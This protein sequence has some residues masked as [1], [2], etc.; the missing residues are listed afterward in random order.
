MNWTSDLFAETNS[1]LQENQGRVKPAECKTGHQYIK[2]T[3]YI[4]TVRPGKPDH[5]L[6]EN[7][8]SD[9][10]RENG[11]LASTAWP[12]LGPKKLL[13]S[14]PHSASTC[15]KQW[16]VE[17]ADPATH[18]SCSIKGRLRILQL[19]SHSDMVALIT[20]GLLAKSCWSRPHMT[21]TRVLGA[22]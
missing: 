17:L 21:R 22:H 1:V 7:R 5:L 10:G 6:T 20:K 13:W 2:L 18:E 16:G 11:A 14:W 4:V 12:Y 15:R 19:A 3:G 8:I 9:Y